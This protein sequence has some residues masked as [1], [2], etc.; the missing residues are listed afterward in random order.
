MIQRGGQGGG[1]LHDYESDKPVIHA[2]LKHAQDHLA[3][4]AAGC[5]GETDRTAPIDEEG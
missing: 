1:P 4:V 5:F 2:T 3:E